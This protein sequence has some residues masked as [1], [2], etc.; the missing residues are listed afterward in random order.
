MGVLDDARNDCNRPLSA[1]VKRCLY[2]G[3]EQVRGRSPSGIRHSHLNSVS[4]FLFYLDACPA[5]QPFQSLGHMT[6]ILN[7]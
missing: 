4:P 7:I 3:T 5:S 2:P 1:S 6:H